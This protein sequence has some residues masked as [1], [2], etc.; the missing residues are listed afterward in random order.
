MGAASAARAVSAL[1][2]DACTLRLCTA[3]GHCARSDFF[4]AF[5]MSF[6][7]PSRLSKIASVTG[8]PDVTRV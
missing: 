5:A 3:C 7:T 4:F 6:H 8:P 1:A 2:R